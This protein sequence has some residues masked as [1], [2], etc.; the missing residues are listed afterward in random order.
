MYIKLGNGKKIHGQDWK[1]VLK[2]LKESTWFDQTIKEYMA[3]VAERAQT[4]SGSRIEY[5]DAETFLKEL[6]R[7]GIIRIVQLRRTK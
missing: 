7:I 4:F 1:E 3:G 2:N 5:S 6:E